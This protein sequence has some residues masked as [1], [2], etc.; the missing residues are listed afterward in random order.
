[1]RISRC[2][3]EHFGYIG[4]SIDV[5]DTL[6]LHC[7]GRRTCSIRVLDDNFDNV[8]PC[9]DDLKSYLEVEYDCIKGGS[10]TCQLLHGISAQ[11]VLTNSNII[12][13]I[14][15]CRITAK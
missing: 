12:E 2:V 13:R 10:L 5:K 11:Y 4:C 15:S 7:S 3:R 9:H 6:D 1:M 14:W 8:R